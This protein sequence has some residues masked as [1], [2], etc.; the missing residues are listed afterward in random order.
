MDVRRYQLDLADAARGMSLSKGN[1]KIC[2]F[3]REKS[4]FFQPHENRLSE[5]LRQGADYITRAGT[6]TQR[7]CIF[8]FLFF[9]GAVPLIYQEPSRDGRASMWWAVFLQ[10]K[11]AVAEEFQGRFGGR[12]TALLGE[13]YWLN[14]VPWDNLT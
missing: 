7:L 5:K 14:A 3:R 10:W 12:W 11:R 6:T 4:Q 2:R 1:V 13:L 9:S 8:V